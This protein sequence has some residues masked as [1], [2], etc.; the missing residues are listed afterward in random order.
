[1][2]SII[3]VDVGGTLLRAA[4]FDDD[5]N[6]LERAK[7]ETHS[8]EGVDAVFDRLVETI[9]Q[10]LPGTPGD[11]SGIG[12][13]LPGPVDSAA[14]VL[15]AAPHLPFKNMPIRQMLAD[16]LN[17]P[18]YIGNDADLA[19]LAEHQRGAG[20]GA[21]TLIYIT[22]ST[23]VG[24]GIIIDG[25]PFSGRG[26]GGEVGHMVVAPDGP[27]CGC[28]HR[29]H[30]EAVAAGS[31]IERIARRRLEAG[32]ESSL[33]ERAGGDLSRV[34]AKMVGEAA[35]AGDPLALSLITDAGRYLGM[36]VASLMMI[37]HPDRFV[38]GGGVTRLGPLL[39]DPM[40]QAVREYA[41]HP[42]YWEKTPLVMA[43][44]KDDVGLTGAAALVKVMA[45]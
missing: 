34:T 7:Q 41:M 26:Q 43:E 20:R 9:R 1:M 2:K 11:L 31:G 35:Q 12:V 13:A 4:R 19:G 28:G 15:I 10:V 38:F 29:G 16:A 42:L 27:M 37:L 5:L 30:L 6:L 21:P 23:G 45:P 25:R 17:A 36:A 22:V 32:E 8:D 3:G 14:G 18:V 33:H 24:S 44:L 39:F 40:K